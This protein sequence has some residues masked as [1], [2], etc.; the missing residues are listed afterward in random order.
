MKTNKTIIIKRLQKKSENSNIK[1]WQEV[2]TENVF[3]IP[4]SDEMTA[5]ANEQ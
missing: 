3:V 5:I 2:G 1:E 4:L